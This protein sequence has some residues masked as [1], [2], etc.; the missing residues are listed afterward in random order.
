MKI[1][2]NENTNL[3][4]NMAAEL[5]SLTLATTNYLYKS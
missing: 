3:S 4:F 1:I 2:L 5:G